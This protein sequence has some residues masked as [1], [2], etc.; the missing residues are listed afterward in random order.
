MSPR[1][2]RACFC[3][4]LIALA[5]LFSI[6]QDSPDQWDAALFL[7]TKAIQDIMDQYN[8][9]VIKIPLDLVPD[10]ELKLART[11]ITGLYGGTTVSID[12]A[13]GLLGGSSIG[14]LTAT[15]TI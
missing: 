15:G 8:G 12:I 11:Q 9:T 14:H 4:F 7:P 2:R 1:K 6:A 5:P 10:V 3:M 13:V